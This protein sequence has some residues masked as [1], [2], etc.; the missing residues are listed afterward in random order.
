M[1]GLV[2][3]ALAQSI[4]FVLPLFYELPVDKVKA[5]R[6]GVLAVAHGLVSTTILITAKL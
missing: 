1:L 5:I 6:D 4:Q 2:G 3:A